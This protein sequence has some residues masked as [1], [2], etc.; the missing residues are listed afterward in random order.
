MKFVEISGATLLK[1]ASRE[2]I[3]DLRSAGVTDESPIRINQQ[4]DIEML[5]DGEWNV[6]GGL[7]G[8]Y[9]NRI[10]KLTGLDWN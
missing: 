8:D 2:E 7:L 4:G 6:I 3:T 5:Q 10:K 9:K 1:L